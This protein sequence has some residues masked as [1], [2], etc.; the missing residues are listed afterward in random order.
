[1]SK[2]ILVRHGQS[3]WNLKNVFTGWVDVPLSKKGIS[4]AQQAGAQLA[5]IAIDCVFTST[6]IRARHT[7]M[8]VMVEQNNDKVPVI[9][10][11]SPMIQEKSQIYDNA[12]QSQITPTYIDWRLNER[13]HGELPGLNKAEI[14]KIW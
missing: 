11:D 2:L 7:A 13:Y 6:L 1:M 14:P 10:N 8:L 3:M 4:E 5:N 12:M 9:I